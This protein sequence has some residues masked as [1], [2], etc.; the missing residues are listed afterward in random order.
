ME[1][2]GQSPTIF[3]L[4]GYQLS[5]SLS[6]FCFVH[7]QVWGECTQTFLLTAQIL[8]HSIITTDLE[9]PFNKTRV[10]SHAALIKTSDCTAS[11]CSESVYSIRF[12]FFFLILQ[13]FTFNY[14]YIYLGHNKLFQALNGHSPSEYPPHCR[15]PWI[16]PIITQSA[17]KIIIHCIKSPSALEK[18]RIVR[19]CNFKK[20]I[21]MHGI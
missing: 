9:D 17:H 14:R 10:L 5:E 13:K 7:A 2:L 21:Y 3:C 11:K 6:H 18:A 19:N 20:Y 4:I 12:Q 1:Q 15:E 16:I 8:S